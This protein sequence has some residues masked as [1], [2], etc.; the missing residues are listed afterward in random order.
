MYVALRRYFDHSPSCIVYSNRSVIASESTEELY[1]D[2]SESVGT[3]LSLDNI[4]VTESVRGDHTSFHFVSSSIR[5]LGSVDNGVHRFTARF[6]AIGTGSIA[7]SVG[8]GVV[9]SRNGV[10]NSASN[11]WEI[12]VTERLLTEG[13]FNPR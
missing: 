10:S 3:S 8:S 7:I 2:F 1:I 12:L 6:R 4:S 5:D 13:V 11:E 9:E